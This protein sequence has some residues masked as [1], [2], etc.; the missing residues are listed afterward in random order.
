M[1]GQCCSPESQLSGALEKVP[2]QLSPFH[3]HC[4]YP[5]VPGNF[6]LALNYKDYRKQMYLLYDESRAGK[7]AALRAGCRPPSRSR[8]RGPGTRTPERKEGAPA[9]APHLPRSARP[10][11]R[12]ATR[13]Q[14]PRPPEQRAHTGLGQI[15]RSRARGRGPRRGSGAWELGEGGREGERTAS[16]TTSFPAHRPAAAGEGRGEGRAAR[17]GAPMSSLSFP[18]PRSPPLPS[19]RPPGSLRLGRRGR[20]GVFGFRRGEPEDGWRRGRRKR[21]R[22]RSRE[23]PITGRAGPGCDHL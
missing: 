10:R 21:E 1:K 6:S 4:T 3:L 23:S 17:A 8:R 14:P 22:G 20:A 7:R 9:A 12:L 2:G 5:K 15:Q 16:V 18:P 19:R 13:P 11:R